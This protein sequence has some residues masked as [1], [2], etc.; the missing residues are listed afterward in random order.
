[1][2]KRDFKQQSMMA[3]EAAVRDWEGRSL[4]WCKPLIKNRLSVSTD[5]AF[6]WL[7]QATADLLRAARKS[8]QY[9]W[10]KVIVHDLRA[11]LSADERGQIAAIFEALL[12]R[13][14]E[15]DVAD[16]AVAK[17][18]DSYDIL[19]DRKVVSRSLAFASPIHLLIFGFGEPKWNKRADRKRDVVIQSFLQLSRVD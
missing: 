15:S 13:H 1:M 11:K 16:F 8:A 19:K 6:A 9:D 14:R 17:L 10:L 2:A 4:D 7:L 18:V 3:I 5:S 12:E